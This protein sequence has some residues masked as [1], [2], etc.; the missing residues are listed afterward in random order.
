VWLDEDKAESPTN[1]PCTLPEDPAVILFTSGTSG[2]AKGVMLSHGALCRSGQLM[3]SMYGWGP[4]DILFSLGDLHT[5]SGLR[6]PAIAAVHAGCS[7][8]TAA[9]ST[10]GSA[11]CAAGCVEKHGITLMTTVPA[12]L[13]LFIRSGDRIP[14]GCLAPLRQV[15]STGSVLPS[16]L[17]RAFEARFGVQ[18]LNYYGLT[19]T[20]GLCI[21]ELPG[22]SRKEP[23]NI[24]LPVGSEARIVDETGTPLPVGEVGEL[25]I[26][27][28]N[29]MTGYY[30]NPQ[31]TKEALSGNWY[32]TGDLARLTA[33][34]RIVLLDRMVDLVKDARGDFIFPGEIEQLLESHPSVVEAGVSAERSFM[35]DLKLSAL[36][37]TATPD[38]LT[39]GLIDELRRHVACRLG[40]TKVP[41]R[42]FQVRELPRGVNGKL[43]RRKFSELLPYGEG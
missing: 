32:R 22:E 7:F 6:N 27:T 30:R 2:E 23:G 39:S 17:V 29:I 34:G 42:F 9:A 31:R 21:G 25:Q 19:E 3:S 13:N 35:G 1:K 33:D 40:P 10:R 4:D 41:A 11:I 20:A 5:M 24:G 26:R 38:P 12:M 15:L 16:P 37:V 43:L 18:V 36:L 8:V 28:S 14:P